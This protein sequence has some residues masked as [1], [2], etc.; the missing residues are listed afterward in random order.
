MHLKKHL[1]LNL[2][3][4][5]AISAC[6]THTD[7]NKPTQSSGIN[8]NTPEVASGWQHKDGWHTQKSAVAAANPMATEAGLKILQQG[9]NALDAAIAVQM[10]LGLVE[11]Q[12]SGIG[13]GAFLLYDDQGSITAFD[14]RETAPAGASENLFIGA[15][16][17]PMSF[18][19]AVVGG[20]SVATPAVISMLHTAHQKHGKLPWAQLLQ[21]AIDLADKGFP[22]SARL[23]KLLKAEK[24]LAANDADA[25]A[26]FYQANGEAV[27]VGHLLKNP[28]YAAVLRLIAAQGPAGLNQGE[29]AQAMVKKVQGHA[30]KGSLSLTDLK[31]YRARERTPLCFD[32]TARQ[33]NY[34]ICGMPPP[35]SGSLTI[36]QILGILAHTDAERFGL[37]NGALDA[38]WLY[39]YG[40]ASRLAFADRNQYIGDPDFVKAP[41]GSWMSLLDKG[42]LQQ[43]AALIDTSAQPKSMNTAKAGQPKALQ[44]AYASMPHQKEY[45]TSHISIVDKYGN[46]LAMTTTIESQFGSKMMVN[47]G[48]GLAGGFL[49]NNEM[50]DFSFTPRDETG[51]PVANRVE[52]N[53]RPRSSMSPTLV[54]EKLPNGKRGKLLMSLGSPGGAN[55]I[56]YTAKTLYASLNW[57]LNAQQA[58]NLPNFGSNNSAMQLEQGLLGD[59][60][61][62]ALKATGQEVKTLEMTSGLQAISRTPNGWFGGADPRREGIVLGE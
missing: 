30:N 25:K 46:A 21:P 16:G 12:S 39:R 9:G 28:E 11:P 32:Y 55:I 52:P 48:K 13:G 1:L 18:D 58:I 14:G 43:R 42:Y 33:Q 23:N 2:S 4:L 60:Y 15:D 5:A 36:A 24:F 35:S 17:K 54:Y 26:Y 47:R 20:R 51:K 3:L 6:A 50:T 45:G 59:A 61:V 29:V 37:N 19:D 8:A 53:K 34:E 7:T 40:E 27:P 49:L 10:V 44:A 31:N 22:V 38:A 62:N 41:A 56:H 57:G